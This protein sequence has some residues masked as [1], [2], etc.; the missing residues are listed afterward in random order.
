MRYHVVFA[1]L[2]LTAVSTARAGENWPRFRGPNGAGVSDDAFP[3]KFEEKD[4]AWKIELPG[5]GHSSPVVWGDNVYV[6]SADEDL[7]KRWLLCVNPA[8]GVIRWRQELDLKPFKKHGENSFASSTPA[9]DDKHV[10]VQ[11]TTPDEFVVYAFTHAGESVWHKDLGSYKTQ[12][13]GGSSPIAVNGLVIVNVDRD[14]PGSFVAAL[15]R[16]TGEI[17]WKTP[18]NSKNFST[19]TPCVY[20]P[21][22]GE[23]GKPVQTQLVF[24]TQA[25][26]LCA[27]DA[28]DGKI[29]WELPDA[30]GA[31]VVSSPVVVGDL[32]VGGCGEGG[33]GIR[34]IAAKPPAAGA[35]GENDDDPQ[36]AFSLTDEIPYVPTPIA[37][38]GRL[39]TWS[40]AGVVTCM[41]AT[42]GQQIW[43]GKVKAG[44]F[45]SPVIA[46]GKLYCVSKRGEVFVV[47][48]TAKDVQQLGKTAFDEASSATPAVAN[49]RM[50]VRT[51]S[52]LICIKGDGAADADK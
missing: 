27:L 15:D 39:F 35:T 28:A 14:T 3:V 7:G 46:G 30:F 25:N 6:T 32:I 33:R 45:A 26:G 21:R 23:P 29:A 8:D 34:T 50:Y 17:R 12:H 42:S 5:K 4:F 41:D 24:A 20:V 1:A 16:D 31:R 18:R 37:Y 19:S 44:F 49:N 43:R 9:A 38:K 51:V 36:I 13:G 11:W 10:Y 48:A 40:D 47:D 52:H 2:L 22:G